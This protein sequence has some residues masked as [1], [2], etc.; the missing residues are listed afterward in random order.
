M[1]TSKTNLKVFAEL[2]A[3]LIEYG[4]A[5]KAEEEAAKLWDNTTGAMRGALRVNK[6]WDEAMRKTIQARNRVTT[7]SSRVAKALV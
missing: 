2:E 4:L 7:L 5:M 3:A 1:V 6:K